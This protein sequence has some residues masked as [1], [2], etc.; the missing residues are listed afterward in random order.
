M[1]WPTYTRSYSF[2]P[3][4]STVTVGP[5]MACILPDIL[6]SLE[7]IL[8]SIRPIRHI[9]PVGSLERR[10]TASTSRDTRWHAGSGVLRNPQP[11]Q[12]VSRV[13]AAR[14]ECPASDFPAPADAL[15][16]IP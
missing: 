4:R 3:L 10:I 1:A 13:R 12:G 9:R 15:Q 16:S 11:Q 7:S 14:E 2:S 8:H 5:D 6:N